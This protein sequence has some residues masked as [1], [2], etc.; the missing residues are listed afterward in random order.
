MPCTNTSS[1][2]N[3]PRNASDTAEAAKLTSLIAALQK[4]DL[5]N[6]VD[7]TAGITVFAPTDAAF[8]AAGVDL[9]AISVD[10]LTKVLQ[11]HVV[12]GVAFSSDLENDQVV[13]TLSGDSIKVSARDGKL[14]INDIEVAQANVALSNGVAHVLNG[15]CTFILCQ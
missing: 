2:L 10:D 12:K 3:L 13:E 11:Y 4:A 9:D 5:V 6:T 14:Y 15:V 1:V 7:T 8:T